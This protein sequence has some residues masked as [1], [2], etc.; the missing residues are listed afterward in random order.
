L[1]QATNGCTQTRASSFLF[2]VEPFDVQL[3]NDPRTYF[4]GVD[5]LEYANGLLFLRD[6]RLPFLQVI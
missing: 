5:Q 6:T 1:Y 3:E 2:E 4:S